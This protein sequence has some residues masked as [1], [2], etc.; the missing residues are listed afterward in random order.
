MTRIADLDINAIAR[1][2]TEY[3]KE[4]MAMKARQL[5]GGDCVKLYRISKEFVVDTAATGFLRRFRIKFTP[6]T[7]NTESG[8]VF[9][10]VVAQRR[11]NVNNDEILIDQSILFRRRKSQNGVQV[12]DNVTDML[13]FGANSQ[14]IKVYAFSTADGE[15]LFEY[16]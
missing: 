12:W 3:E 7:K 15:L 2:V 9:R 10:I 6:N 11:T 16:L 13:Y 8:I 4:V 14:Q 1:I 5:V